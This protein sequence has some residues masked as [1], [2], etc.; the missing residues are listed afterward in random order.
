MSSGTTYSRT[1][2]TAILP[3]TWK[4]VQ[5]KHPTQLLESHE[6]TSWDA[7]SEAER[8]QFI[9]LA[10]QKLTEPPD[11][12]AF[13]LAKNPYAAGQYPAAVPAAQGFPANGYLAP[14][15]SLK[16][17]ASQLGIS[18]DQV[19]KELSKFSGPVSVVKLLPP[20]KIYRT[21]GLTANSVSYGSVTNQILGSYWEP[22]C[23]SDYPTIDAW[24]QATA[25]LA[26]WNG[27][28]GYVE[29]ILDRELTV[30]SGTTGM[31]WVDSAN[32]LVLPGGGQQY[33]VP[34]MASQL[35]ELAQR[36][37]AE[38]LTSLIQPTR[39]GSGKP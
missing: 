21:V 20:T 28:Y 13:D 38:P 9:A 22:V 4:A 2:G 18:E 37:A 10:L 26:E 31:Q 5:A 11:F 25:V 3:R 23:P 27:D 34:N 8:K 16:S 30:L 6:R 36:V 19:R 15:Q 1:S 24:R 32:N 7:V 33:F 12:L 35:P 17:A 39:F 29:V 14:G